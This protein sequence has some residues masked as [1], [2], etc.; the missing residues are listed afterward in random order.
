[1]SAFCAC[2][3]VE[4]RDTSLDHAKSCNTVDNA[5]RSPT[6]ANKANG[7]NTL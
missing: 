3:L 2:K 1:M 5:V 6:F 4:S 7:Y